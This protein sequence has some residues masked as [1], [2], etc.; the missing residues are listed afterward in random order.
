MLQEKKTRLEHVAYHDSLTS[1]PNRTLLADRL[2]QTM[3]Q[4]N[5]RGGQ[6]AVAYLDLD[7]FKEINDSYGHDVGDLFLVALSHRVKEILRESDTIARLG[8]DEF[9]AVLVDLQESKDSIP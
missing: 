1:L 5:R 4:V 8:G 3:A 7:G 6:L 9:V 2:N